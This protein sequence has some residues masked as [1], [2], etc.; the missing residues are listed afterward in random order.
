MPVKFNLTRNYADRFMPF[1]LKTIIK[2]KKHN[3]KIFCLMIAAFLALGL[4]FYSKPLLAQWSTPGGQALNVSMPMHT[5]ANNPA[6]EGIKS[7]ALG[8]LSDFHVGITDDL[9][10]HRLGGVAIGTTTV[11]SGLI[12]DV[13]GL[14]GA[15]W[16][17]KENGEDC[18]RAGDLVSGG[19][20]YYLVKKGADTF[21]G[22]KVVYI[23]EDGNFAFDKNNNDSLSANTAGVG[24]KNF[25]VKGDGSIVIVETSG[26]IE[27]NNQTGFDYRIFSHLD[28][29]D[30]RIFRIDVGS[31]SGVWPHDMRLLVIDPNSG[32][33][34]S[35]FEL[36]VDTLIIE[37][38]ESEEINF[39]NK[40]SNG[41]VYKIG[42]MGTHADRPLVVE[43]I[44]NYFNKK[45]VNILNPGSVPIHDLYQLSARFGFNDT[46][47]AFMGIHRYV[48]SDLPFVFNVEGR[49]QVSGVICQASDIK[50]KRDAQTIDKSLEKVKDLRGVYFDWKNKEDDFHGRE[51]GVIAQE[52]EKV[53][54]EAVSGEE[55]K[56]VSYSVLTALLFSALN[57]LNSDYG[58]KIEEQKRI[59]KKI[60][61]LLCR[62]DN[63][64]CE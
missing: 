32:G 44:N 26:S 57:E 55:T 7:G 51:V 35:R 29:D 48:I 34:Q 43:K 2:I 20:N 47:G 64:F 56:F 27:F 14:V 8:I 3:Q 5:G 37:E 58:E 9:Y 22:E 24:D 38:P 54:P 61:D 31:A 1:L 59:T 28:T 30:D 52:V 39:Y 49:V 16:Y 13:N 33:S 17:C 42:G 45:S 62:Q 41:A 50:Y 15:E 46:D 4:F 40:N 63:E 25:F 53:L 23:D 19:S 60:N 11:S 6:I 36:R 18:V 21:T 10:V 12:L